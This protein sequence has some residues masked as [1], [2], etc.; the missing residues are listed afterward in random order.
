MKTKNLQKLI[1]GIRV[2]NS[3]KLKY[4]IVFIVDNIDSVQ[5]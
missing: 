5:T 2:Q 1:T 3:M 4:E